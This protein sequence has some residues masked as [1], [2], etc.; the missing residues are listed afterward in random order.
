MEGNLYNIYDNGPIAPVCRAK[1]NLAIWTENKYIPYTVEWIEPIQPSRPYMVDLLA[2]IQPAATA[3]AAAG[4]INA[5]VLAI[6]QMNKDELLH[7]RWEPLDD[8]EG[9]LF[10]LSNMARNASRG[11]QARTSLFTRLHDPYLSTTTFWILGGDTAKDAQIQV[12]NPQGVAVYTCRF[13]FYGFR[14]ILTRQTGNP[15]GNITYLPAQ[16]R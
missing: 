7:I 11:G 6:L 5:Q 2:T 16:G 1:E 12:T 13:V 8:V 10:Q 14:Y 9:A 4:Q 15:S 3:L